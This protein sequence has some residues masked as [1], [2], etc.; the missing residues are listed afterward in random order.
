MGKL[1][2]KIY[3]YETLSTSFGEALVRDK[4]RY[5]SAITKTLNDFSKGK[6]DIINV[7]FI[8]TA[9]IRALN[10]KY[11]QKDEPTDVLSFTLSDNSKTVGEIYICLNY[12]KKDRRL[13]MKEVLRMIVHGYL[14][15]IGYNHESYFFEDSV[16][17]ESKTEKIFVEQERLLT[18]ISELL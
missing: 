4:R 10:N 6:S 11:R 2:L 18:K 1:E 16:V 9:K 12:L 13:T 17:N 5:I 3:N 15:I 14:H 8:S 7:I